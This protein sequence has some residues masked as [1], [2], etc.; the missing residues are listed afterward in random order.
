MPR[1]FPVRNSLEFFRSGSR[2]SIN[3]LLYTLTHPLPSVP[4]PFS[5]EKWQHGP[6]DIRNVFAVGAV[7]RAVPPMSHS[8]AVERNRAS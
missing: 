1:F 5:Y 3:Y 2:V 7:T 8:V 6:F 4:C